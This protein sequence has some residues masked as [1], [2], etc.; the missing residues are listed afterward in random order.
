MTPVQT[1]ITTTAQLTVPTMDATVRVAESDVSLFVIDFTTG[2]QQGCSM[3][4][5]LAEAEDLAAMLVE[6]AAMCRSRSLGTRVYNRLPNGG[7]AQ[8]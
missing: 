5:T 4:L 2:P 3:M 1:T 8:G 7:D 6:T